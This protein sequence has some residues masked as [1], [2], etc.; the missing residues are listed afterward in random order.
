MRRCATRVRIW[1]S[2]SGA[3]TV[4]GSREAS[5]G[6]SGRRNCLASRICGVAAGETIQG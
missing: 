6:A 1:Y 2:A 4:N 5:T 3:F